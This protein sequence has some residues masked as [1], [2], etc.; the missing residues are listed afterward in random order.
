MFLQKKYRGYLQDSETSTHPISGEVF[1][2]EKATTIFDGIT[3]SK[4]ASTLKCLLSIIGEENFGKA[5]DKY[6]HKYAYGNTEL[7]D[8]LECIQEQTDV[9]I[10]QW[11]DQ[12][13]QKA[14]YNYLIPQ[15]LSFA[16]DKKSLLIKQG[17]VN[18]DHETLRYHAI[19]IGFFNENL[20]VVAVKEVTVPNKEEFHIDVTDVPEY[21]AVFMNFEDQDF[22]QTRF[23]EASYKFFKENM[24]SFEDDLT[25]ALILRAFFDSL[26]SGETTNQDWN[27]IVCEFIT[28]ET[29][30]RFL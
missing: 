3:Y 18:Q 9:D 4:G 24:T 2:T 7:K 10:D 23:D 30:V 29:K 6:F 16:G 25:R 15:S 28:V 20:E 5:M 17:I 12:W 21:K 19:K 8:L 27:D 14:G 11:R 22:V 1:D 26:L 13:I